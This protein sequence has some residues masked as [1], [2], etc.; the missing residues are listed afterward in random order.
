MSL[1][2]SQYSVVENNTLLVNVSLN[3]TITENITVTVMII[4]GSAK[5]NVRQ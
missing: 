5:G 4:D 3:A 1:A 2:Q